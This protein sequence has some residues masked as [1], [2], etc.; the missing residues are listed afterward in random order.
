MIEMKMVSKRFGAKTVLE[1][2]DL[3]IRKGEVHA[4]LGINGA[5]KSTL[6]KILARLILQDTGKILYDKET[7]PDIGFNK[8]IGFVFDEPLYIPYFSAKEYLQFVCKL[9]ISLRLS[10]NWPPIFLFCAIP[11]L[12]YACPNGNCGKRQKNQTLIFRRM[13][14]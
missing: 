9:R 1:N 10:P 4:L 6:I 8:S 2:V 13:R 7:P 3:E 11:K 12:F 14:Q 5:G